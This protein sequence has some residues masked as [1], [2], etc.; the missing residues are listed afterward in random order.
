M[1]LS[2]GVELYTKEMKFILCKL[3]LSKL[4][5]EKD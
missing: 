4:G 3:Y 5:V 1:H 2:N